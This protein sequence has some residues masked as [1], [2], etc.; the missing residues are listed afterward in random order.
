MSKISVTDIDATVGRRIQLRRKELRI[1]AASLSEKI[2]ISQQQLSRY[3]RGVNKIN[4]SHLFHIS[5]FLE[6]PISWF[7]LDCEVEEAFQ[8][9]NQTAPYIAMQDADL[10]TRLQQVWTTLSRDQ[11]RKLIALLDA[12]SI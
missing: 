8:I 7:F 2:G 5:V 11:Q 4:V 1:S 12:F 9:S 10:Q 6:S 3:E